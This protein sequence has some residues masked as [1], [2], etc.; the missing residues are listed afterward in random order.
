MLFDAHDSSG[1]E[2]PW[3][4]PVGSVL[5]RRPLPP[6]IL[7]VVLD[8][9]YTCTRPVEGGE[10]A[11]EQ[12]FVTS[13]AT[14][15]GEGDAALFASR[16]WACKQQVGHEP[17]QH[18]FVFKESVGIVAAAESDIMMAT[19]AIGWLLARLYYPHVP[20]SAY[21]NMAYGAY[22]A[23]YPLLG[24]RVVPELRTLLLGLRARSVPATVVTNSAADAVRA[25]LAAGLGDEFPEFLAGIHGHAAKFEIDE[26]WEMEGDVSVPSTAS[27]GGLTYPVRLRRRSYRDA[28]ARICEA[29][30]VPYDQ[31]LVVGDNTQLDLMMPHAIGMQVA[32]VESATTAACDRAWV[33]DLS[34]L[35][36]RSPVPTLDRVLGFFQSSQ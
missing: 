8:A 19:H 6:Q 12:A 16:W 29:S 17:G 25:N 31:V 22:K 10:E 11:Y 34:H 9:D 28:L 13:L 18:G 2:S 1:F 35:G 30:R 7:H 15:L 14:S 23:G 36:W 24:M 20:H 3:R 5:D 26:R 4:F 27:L 21:V 32:L 33:R